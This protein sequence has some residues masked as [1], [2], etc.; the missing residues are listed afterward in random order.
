M[1][2]PARFEPAH[3]GF[4]DPCLTTWLRHHGRNTTKKLSRTSATLVRKSEG[5]PSST[6]GFLRRSV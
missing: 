2:V 4:A 1:E 6:S 3:G 5:V